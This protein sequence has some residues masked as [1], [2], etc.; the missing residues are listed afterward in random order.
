M[1]VDDESDI[2]RSALK[3]F[4]IRYADI[5]KKHV[6]RWMVDAVK[7][8]VQEI[9]IQI[10]KDHSAY[11]IPHILNCKSLRKLSMQLYGAVGYAD[12]I[13][14][15]SM[16]LPQL[17]VLIRRGL[18]ISN[19]E[20][21]KR[22]FSSC[23]SLETLHIVDCDIQTDNQRNFT[24]D[25]L[26][27][28]QFVYG[29][30][31]RRLLPQN[32]NMA[33][34]IKLCARNLELFACRSFLAQD[35]SLNICFPISEVIFQMFLK[36]NEEDEN[37]ESYSYLY[38][39]EKEV[40]AKRVMQFLEAFY[41]VENLS[42][43]SGFLEVLSQDLDFLDCQPPRLCDLQTLTLGMWS[44]RGCLRAVIYLL[45]ISPYITQLFLESK[46]FNLPDVGDD[47]E[48]GF[49][50]PGILSRLMLVHF[51]EVDG[52]DAELKL[53]SFC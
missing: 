22:L 15:S 27:L 6:G 14:P 21:S 17:K 32:G 52:C 4:N 5:M 19:V 44:T 51:V 47:W 38:S 39:E 11:K 13:L 20:S 9:T 30:S 42:L 35:Y 16:S 25:I 24:V 7:H 26:S 50:F 41:K 46:E 28:K 18:S 45:K 48:S 49:S 10:C 23:P 34:I 2:Q 37:A 8:N 40:Y 12:I 1:L 3:W 29:C 31:C 33:N 53:L 36:E 43:S